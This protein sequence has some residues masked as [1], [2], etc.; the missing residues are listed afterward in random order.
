MNHLSPVL[1]PKDEIKE[2]AK[3]EQKVAKYSLPEL[4]RLHF[5]RVLGKYRKCDREFILANLSS[6]ERI[7]KEFAK[8]VAQTAESALFDQEN[9]K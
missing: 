6:E 7:V 2:I 5:A 3:V 1:P 4:Y 8:L 9:A